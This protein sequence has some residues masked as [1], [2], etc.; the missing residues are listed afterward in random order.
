MKKII[1]NLLILVAIVQISFIGTNAFASE[2]KQLDNKVKIDIISDV[3]CPWCAIG[4]KRLSQAIK[5]LNMEDNVQIVWHP[6]QLNPNMPREGQ[7][8]DQYLMKKLR[9][10]EEQLA[11]KRKSV[12][13]TGKE[14]GFTFNYSKTMKK[15]NTFNAHI[16]L[17]YAQEFNKQT[18]LKVRLQEAYFSEEKDIS[19]R[20]VL[21]RELDAVG[22]NVAD[23]MARLDDHK[24]I[25]RVQK[26]EKYWRDRGVYSIPTMLFDEKEVKVGARS[27]TE[28]KRLL[29]ILIKNKKEL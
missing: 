9:L 13:Q 15:V 22:L 27:V 23:A 10:S 25:K 3:V 4:Y 5:E 2:I 16:L 29:S 20:N 24:V 28:Y 18:E 14:S 8:A 7:N 26:E 11:Q 21:V 1:K 17:D 19:N 6:F 12:T